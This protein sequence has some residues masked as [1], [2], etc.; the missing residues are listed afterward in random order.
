MTTFPHY[1]TTL[2]YLPFKNTFFPAELPSNK[3]I[4][5]LHGRGGAS[6]DFTWIAE[7]FDFD[8]MHYLFLDAPTTYDEGYSWYDDCKS[9]QD[10]SKL[11]TQTLDILF[12]KDFDASKSFLFGFSQG[13][14]LTFEFGA[15]YT[16]R[17][18]GYIA[19]SGQLYDPKLLLE[20]M[21]PELK[22]ANWLCTHGTKDE[23]LD[24]N[25]TKQQI[26]TLK[27][28]GFH[29]NFQSY[30]K[31]HMIEKKEADMLRAWIKSLSPV[32]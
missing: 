6:T 14:L 2:D 27:K 30:D 23:A 16:K 7:S 17:L 31:T 10:I 28:G 18:A 26:E 25:I 24:F 5:I 20:E 15:R 22:N 29:I 8:D 13:A 1:L 19:I 9:I 11:L 3:L 12:R 32:E 4:I 21:N